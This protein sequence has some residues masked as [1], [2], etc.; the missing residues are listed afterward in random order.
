V[1]TYVSILIYKNLTRSQQGVQPPPIS[2]CVCVTIGIDH[3]DVHTKPL[4]EFVATNSVTI[5]IDHMDVHTKP[6][7]KFVATN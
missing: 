1:Y 2:V 4:H 7:H 3:M 5:G 6:L